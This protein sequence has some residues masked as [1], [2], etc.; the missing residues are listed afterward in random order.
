[1]ATL[2]AD[3]VARAAAVPRERVEWLT[4]LGMLK[5]AQPGSYRYGDVFRLQL[6][7]AL[8][9]AG[10]TSE[11]IE[12]AKSHG[13][14]SLDHVDQ[15]YPEDPDPPSARTFAEFSRDAASKGFTLPAA[16]EV[17]GL[18]QPDPSTP[19]GSHDEELMQRFVDGWS[20]AGDDETLIRAARLMAEGTRVIAH[21]WMGLLDEKVAGP[22]RER[23]LRR[24]I[25]TFPEDVQHAFVELVKLAPEMMKWLTLRYLE[26]RAFEGILGGFEEYLASRDLGP[27]PPPTPPP[28]VVFVDIS[29]YTRITEERG[30]QVAAGFAETLVRE[31]SAAAMA[32]DGRLVKLLGDGAMLRLP[33]AERGVAAALDLTEALRERGDLRAH[34]GVHAGPV[35]ERD[36]DLYGRTVNLASR[37]AEV[38]RPGEVLVSET[39]ADMAK[40]SGVRFEPADSPPLKGVSEKVTLFRALP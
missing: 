16:F 15:Y 10:F 28:A 30:D 14:L 37:I 4:R 21:G 9:E 3:E 6:I 22:A 5:P 40:A 23:L 7:E 27:P 13:Q 17:L 38:A 32:N 26:R 2:S 25:E 11:Q 20:I 18:P 39:V 29:G 31:A 24:E 12:R 34:A 35:I 19:M 1:M 33:D 8:L 36:L